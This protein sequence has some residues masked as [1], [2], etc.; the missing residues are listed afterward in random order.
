M[1]AKTLKFIDTYIDVDKWFTPET[2][3]EFTCRKSSYAGCRYYLG[4]MTNLKRCTIERDDYSNHFL[5]EPEERHPPQTLDY[6][7]VLIRIYGKPEILLS[8]ILYQR[9]EFFK[10]KNT[11]VAW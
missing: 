1:S 10:S 4:E 3:E 6:Y 11:E 5:Y 7:S 9:S 8:D 2:I